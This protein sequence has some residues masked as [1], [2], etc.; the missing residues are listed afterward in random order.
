MFLPILNS[1]KGDNFNTFNN[2]LSPSCGISLESYTNKKT[3]MLIKGFYDV[4]GR[5]GGL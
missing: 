4:L 5:N 3:M 2:N 1:V